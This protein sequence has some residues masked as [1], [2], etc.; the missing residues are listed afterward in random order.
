MNNSEFNDFDR[1]YYEEKT[2]KG[3]LGENQWIKEKVG[4]IKKVIPKEVKHIVDVGCGEGAIT[5]TLVNKYTVI[6]IDRSIPRLVFS[7]S[8]RVNGNILDLPL[9]DQSTD[10]VIAS[11]VLEHLKLHDLNA[12]ISE[13]QRVS[14]RYIL[15]TVP[16]KENLKKNYVKCPRCSYRFNSSHHFQ[17]FTEK[18]LRGLFTDCSVEKVF[19]CG[20]RVRQYNPVLLWIKH[21][22]ANKWTNMPKN[23]GTYV[24]PEC[25]NKF[26]YEY[27]RNSLSFILDGLNKFLSPRNPY[28]IGILFKSRLK[29]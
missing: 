21:E 3:V 17:S 15:I 4:I 1:R 28:W 23:K 24:C 20:N 14:R 29:D 13:L 2:H 10:L 26:F 5:N 9:Q 8:H 11:E 6:G 7:K 18:R 22:I 12:A 27:V 25:G 16:Y 19:K